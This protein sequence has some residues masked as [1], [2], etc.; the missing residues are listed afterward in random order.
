MIEFIKGLQLHSFIELG[1]PII[2]L[3]FAV[4]CILWLLIVERLLFLYWDYPKQ[5]QVCVN[6][7]QQRKDRKSWAAQRIRELMISQLQVKLQRFTS[8]INVLIALCPLLG[9]LGTVT[10]MVAVFDTI[11]ITGNSDAKAMA[12]GIYKATL[13]TMSGLVLAISAL[14]FNFSIQ[15]KV[16]MNRDKIADL[17][18]T[19]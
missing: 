10:G 14:Y 13:P 6:A 12:V 4:A 11:A 3:L 18:T 1:G 2:P 16:K 19:R 15:H 7:W 17:L 9:L 8:L 5:E